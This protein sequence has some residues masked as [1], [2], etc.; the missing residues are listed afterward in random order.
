MVY[1][2]HA[3]KSNRLKVGKADNVRTRFHYLMREN[4]DD[5]TLL[6]SI[7]GD[8]ETEQA[9]H[10]EL[11]EVAARIHNEFW[12]Y[13]EGARQLVERYVYGDREVVFEPG[14]S[15]PLPEESEPLFGDANVRP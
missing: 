2:I 15:F 4:A 10:A 3:L 14:Q 13:N 12:D 9:I 6:G 1:F 8:E 11:D 7:P 5:L